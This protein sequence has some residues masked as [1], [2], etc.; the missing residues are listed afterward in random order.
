MLNYVLSYL[1]LALLFLFQTTLSR[2]IDICG[3]APNLIFTFAVCYSMYNFPV[4]S[5]V[6]CAVAGI[7]ADLYSH[8]YVGVNALLYMYTGIA[9]SNFA[10][11]LIRKNVW[12]AWA[13]VLCLS[14]LY[15]SIIL[16]IDFVIPGHSG[17]VYPFLRFAIPTAVY[18]SVVSFVMVLL[19]RWLS[20][21]K[22]RGL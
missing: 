17:F 22:I 1:S 3:I 9:I 15:H 21:D 14:V 4:R 10:S 16:I 5:A 11:S 13:G 20:E 6:L 12:T 19:T 2:Y 8:Q 7:V 18:D